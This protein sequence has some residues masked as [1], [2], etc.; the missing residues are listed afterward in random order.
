MTIGEFAQAVA[1]YCLLTRASETSGGR[2]VRHNEAVG[3]VAA[4]PHL[5]FRGRD[6]VYDQV[7]P[8]HYRIDCAR[9]LGLLVIIEDDHDHLQPIDWRAG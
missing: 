3:G 9:R 4:S 8:T 5:Y 7:P 2:T 6:V 1:E